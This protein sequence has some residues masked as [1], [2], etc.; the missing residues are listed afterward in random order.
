MLRY[1]YVY[2]VNICKKGILVRGNTTLHYCTLPHTSINYLSS[3]VSTVANTFISKVLTCRQHPEK[4]K[5]GGEKTPR[6]KTASVLMTD[7]SNFFPCISPHLA[8]SCDPFFC[9]LHPTAVNASLK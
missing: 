8:V 7:P 3:R 5:R 6:E 2:A 9:A 4:G 1:Q